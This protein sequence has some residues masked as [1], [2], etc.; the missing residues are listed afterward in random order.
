MEVELYLEILNG[1]QKET[2]IAICE[3]L[4]IGRNQGDLLIEDP[5]ISGLHA[6]IYFHKKHQVFV[7][8]DKNSHHKIKFK[9]Q[10]VDRLALVPGIEFQLGDTLLRVITSTQLETL[11]PLKDWQKRTL[12]FIDQTLNQIT[13]TALIEHFVALEQP[14]SLEVVEG[15]DIGN[16]WVLGFLP[17]KCGR[18]SFDIEI[19][20]PTSPF[21]AFE[22]NP[23]QSGK[24]IQLTTKYPAIVRFNNQAQYQFDLES[25]C[26]VTVGQSKIKVSLLLK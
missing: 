16:S 26:L 23:I 15:V 24:K 10:K 11:K 20:E 18:S 4:T 25:D 17:R 6:S 19:N 3:G 8:R 9:D 12:A 7:L 5:R 21:I 22:I 13:E 1:P 14:I 2:H